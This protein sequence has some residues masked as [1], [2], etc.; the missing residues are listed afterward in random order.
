VI[1]LK[2]FALALMAIIGSIIHT[3][4][5]FAQTQCPWLNAAT[6][7]GVLGGEVEASITNATTLGDATCHFTRKQDSS[8]LSITIDVHTMSLPSK[9][10]PTFTAQCGG[11]LSPLKAIGNEAFQC[12]PKSTSANGEEQVIGRVRDRAF[13]LTV[14]ANSTKQSAPGKTSL[15]PETRNLA[16]QVAGSLF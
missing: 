11:T 4:H 16:E 10:F 12:V 2:W 14:N 6:A 8:N 5:C 15:T 9:D 3:P 7:G 13:I 1:K